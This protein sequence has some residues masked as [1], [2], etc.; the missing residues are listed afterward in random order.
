MTDNPPQITGM[1]RLHGG[2]LQE[3]IAEEQI[4]KGPQEYTVFFRREN[5]NFAMYEP[6]E[7]AYIGAWLAPETS[8]RVFE[9]QAKKR[10]AVF[11]HEIYLGDEIP[12]TWLL[13][14]IASLTTPLF[15]VHPPN[16]PDL[17]DIPP[18]ELVVQLAQRLGSFNLPMF[19]AFYP[20]APENHGLM[21]AEYSHFFSQSRNIF[22]AH[23]PMAAFAWVAP[24][25]S[26]TPK[27]PYFPVNNVDWVALPLLANWKP[28]NDY[29]N[30]I[31]NF[32]TFYANFNEHAPIMILPLGVS[33]F[34]RGDYTYRLSQAAAEIS[35]VYEALRYFPRLGLV[36]YGDAFT[37][38]NSFNDDFSVSIETELISAYSDAIACENFLQTLQR[39][40]AKTTRWVR[41]SYRGYVWENKIYI[42]AEL[43][44]SRQTVMINDSAFVEARR[45]SDK[46][47]NLCTVKR[48][49]YLDNK[50]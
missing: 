40:S 47:I 25:Y 41:S 28:E 8:I 36:A 45:I 42:P 48:V 1:P 4:E 21:P 26:A 32:E 18:L 5:E 17:V 16:N 35:H 14:C 24:C 13:H 38:A 12:I 39:D 22:S 15:I 37:L 7:G 34:T 2:F 43:V 11:V 19:I 9:H 33:H 27:N 49:I 20:A 44:P 3:T 23:A 10:H 6:S 30:I 50:H 29:T 31:A 46:K